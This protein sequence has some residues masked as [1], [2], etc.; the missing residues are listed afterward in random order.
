M[1][2]L[3]SPQMAPVVRSLGLPGTLVVL[4]FDGTLAPIVGDRRAA[5]LSA[6]AAVALAR[7]ATRYPVAV[8]S[9]RAVGDVQERL[10]GVAVTWVVG[11]HGAE[12]PGE[13]GRHQGWLDQVA[14]WTLT[15]TRRLST[16]EGVELEVKPLSL[17]VHFRHS[18]RPAEAE[19]RI[20]EATA[21]LAGAV[22][23]L[24]KMVVNLLPGGAG[25]KGTALQRLVTLAGASRVLFIGDDVTD[26]AAF[27]AALA[28]PS[29]MVRVGRYPGSL[30]SAWL[31]HQGDVEVL[32]DQLS[33][34]RPAAPAP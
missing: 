12:W 25:D 30:A 22:V 23:V 17:T 13:E 10:A 20:G 32:L 16:L 8:L 15:L 4:D 33:D 24:G 5:Q 3:L 11:S 18:P 26:E 34:L 29:V 31:R 2:D 14:G 21:D 6:S 9:G 27:G 19:A 1:N 28:I 7:L